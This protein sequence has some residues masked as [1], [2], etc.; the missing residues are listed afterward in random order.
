[1]RLEIEKLP[2]GTYVGESYLD[3]DGF[4]EEPILIRVA[5]T[6]DGDEATLEYTVRDE[7][8]LDYRRTFTPPPLRGQGI[9]KA[10]VLFGLDYARANGLKI[11]PTCP[12]VEKVIRENPRY[13]DLVA[14]AS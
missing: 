14:R 11:V 1:M 4:Q 7:G 9:A 13:A 5:I 8:V 10:V 12:Y 6:I 2:D 3:S